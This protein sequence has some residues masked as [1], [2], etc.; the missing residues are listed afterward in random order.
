MK[1]KR[2]ATLA[3]VGTLSVL[4]STYA[5]AKDQYFGVAMD[6]S[7]YDQLDASR[8]S[9]DKV[10]YY[11]PNNPPPEIM[12]YCEFTYNR[13]S[14]DFMYMNINVINHSES[15]IETNYFTDVFKVVTTS[16]KT[17]MLEKPEARWYPSAQYINPDSTVMY[18]LKVPEALSEYIK[19]GSTPK[20]NQIKYI[21]CEFGTSVMRYKIVLVPIKEPKETDV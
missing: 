8:G 7:L 21:V 19:S 9:D 5:I 6:E 12:A 18:N 3:I 16:G 10:S 1:I 14:Y 4:F 15:P 11:L 13:Y 2:V 20:R 17:F